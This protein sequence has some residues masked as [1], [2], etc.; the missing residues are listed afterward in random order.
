[1]FSMN[2]ATAGLIFG[3]PG[4]VDGCSAHKDFY[5]VE[6][7]PGYI[8]RKAITCRIGSYSCIYYKNA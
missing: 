6:Q 8:S 5:G 1:M 4:Y 3:S 2:W 7:L